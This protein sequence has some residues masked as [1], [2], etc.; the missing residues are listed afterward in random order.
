MSS[1]V[2]NIEKIV[3]RY[4]KKKACNISILQDIFNI[5]ILNPNRNYITKK[6]EISGDIKAVKAYSSTTSKSFDSIVKH[7]RQLP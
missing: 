6:N 5:L 1:F 3:H 4:D 7:Y 2:S